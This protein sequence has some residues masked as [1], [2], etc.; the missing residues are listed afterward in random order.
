[1][2]PGLEGL[3]AGGASRSCVTVL[4]SGSGPHAVLPA[5]SK[6]QQGPPP[7]R[8]G[9]GH[10]LPAS[11]SFLGVCWVQSAWGLWFPEPCDRVSP[12]GEFGVESIRGSCEVDAT[13]SAQ[14]PSLGLLVAWTLRFRSLEARPLPALGLFVGDPA[15]LRGCK[16]DRWGQSP[17]PQSWGRS[18]HSFQP[19]SPF[20]SPFWTFG[21][22]DGRTSPRSHSQRVDRACVSTQLLG[23]AALPRPLLPCLPELPSA[24]LA[25]ALSLMI[26]AEPGSLGPWRKD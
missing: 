26:Q 22:T 25:F 6:G 17:P 15:L 1:M 16:L 21:T 3:E 12:V 4:A 7:A 13:S 24:P 5:L 19:S 11:P 10:V 20:Q 14:R 23:M 18:P 9:A 2:L 8:E